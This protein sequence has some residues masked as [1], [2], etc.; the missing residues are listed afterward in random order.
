MNA[1][2]SYYRPAA[3]SAYV[4]GNDAL[5]EEVRFA[6]PVT[7][8]LL[9]LG[10]L[11]VLGASAYVRNAY[12]PDARP[13]TLNCPSGDLDLPETL[14]SG[15][16]VVVLQEHHEPEARQ[17]DGHTR[18]LTLPARCAGNDDVAVRVLVY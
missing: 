13:A 10:L 9:T 17:F 18:R 7:L 1:P 4:A 15:S 14:S 5:R 16:T 8:S 6:N 3:W 11:G 12:L 2:I